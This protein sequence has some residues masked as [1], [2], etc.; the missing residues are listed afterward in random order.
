L[1]PEVSGGFL[2]F[3]PALSRTSDGFPAGAH[4]YLFQAEQDHFWFRSRNKI[5]FWALAKYFRDAVNLLEIGCG[6]GYVLQGI[7]S[8]FPGVELHGSEI[9][10]Q[11]LQFAAQRVPEASLYQMDAR[12][13]PFRDH[14]D[15]IGA[16]DVLEHVEDDQSVLSEMFKAVKKR[17]GGIV[18]TVPQHQFLWSVA[19]E[20]SCHFRRYSQS[21]LR[22]KAEKA[23]FRVLKMTSFMSFTLPLLVAARAKRRHVTV[24]DFDPLFE[25]R[26]P[27]SFN[28]FLYTVLTVERAVLQCGIRLPFGSSLLMV[29]RA[30]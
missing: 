28:A 22:S 9:Y 13:I 19:D 6:T 14:F 5:I 21:E 8:V 4:E 2:S 3:A 17:R 20:F 25:F 15:V 29:A 18:I 27:K 10:N 16:F 24:K 1:Q 26:L 11:G 7:H 12:H 30:E 23:G